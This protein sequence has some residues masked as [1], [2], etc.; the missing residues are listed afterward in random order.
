MTLAN[1]VQFETGFGLLLL[2]LQEQRELF[3]TQHPLT[4]LGRPTGI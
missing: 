2:L 4:R 1:L 3:L